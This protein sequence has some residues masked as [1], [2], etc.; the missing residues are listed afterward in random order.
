MGGA[1]ALLTDLIVVFARAVFD[2]ADRNRNGVLDD[3]EVGA[4]FNHLIC[5][6]RAR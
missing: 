6:R 4:R 2:E 5:V 1:V 3:G